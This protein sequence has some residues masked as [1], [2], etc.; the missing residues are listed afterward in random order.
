MTKGRQGA[1]TPKARTGEAPKAHHRIL[2]LEVTGGFLKDAKFEFADGL[3]CI[4]G[5]RGTGKTTVLEFV[6]Y[7]LALVPEEKAAPSR[8][9]SV[10]AIVQSNLGTGRI[11]LGVQTKHGMG[12]LAERPWNDSAQVLNEQGEAT[13]ISFERDSIFKADVYSQNEI[14]EIA[15][16]TSL[17]LSLLDKFIEDDVRRIEGEVRKLHRDLGQNAGELVRLDREMRDLRDSATEVPVLEE[18][19]KALQQ[20]AGPDAKIVNAAH[21]LKALRERERKT[22]EALR[23]DLRQVHTDVD[24]LFTGLK[25][26]V[27]SR[28]DADVAAGPNKDVFDAIAQHV[29][30]LTSLLDRGATKIGQQADAADGEVAKREATLAE[31]HAKQDAEYRDLVAKSQEETGRVTERTQLQRRYAEVTTARKELELRQKERHEREVRR[32]ELTSKLSDLRDERFRLRKNVAEHL[33]APLQP[34]IRVTITQA[35]NRDGYRALLTE[36]LKGQSMRY[37]A[38][39]DRIVQSASPDE[40]SVLVQRNDAAR[41]AERTGVD[42]DRS[43]KVIE[44]L[45][46]TEL[47]YR[48]E[49]IELEDLPRIELLD[50]RDY[51]DSAGLSTGQ[52]CTTI[53]PILLLESERPLLVDQPE[54]NLDNRYIYETVVKSLSGAKGRRQLIFVTHNPNIPV[55]GNAER[56]FVLTSDG[57]QGKLSKVGTVDEL[58]QEIE[59]LLEGGS[60]AFLLRKERYGH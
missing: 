59:L 24:S 36:A 8:A 10:K 17:Q 7:V 31:R 4:I 19:L 48:L 21:T 2:S 16:N 1:A 45:R 38:V 58:K 18:K 14:E 23:A 54:D 12:Y 47:L 29:K 13:A 6:R 30:E 41:L 11:R 33:L 28:V 52:R 51:K 53:L 39:V 56:V 43:K 49:T 57:K 42:E 3:N 37:T 40:L 44:A 22:L 26:R 34:T 15:T 32:Q 27:E 35:A 9:R 20:A 25:R 5:G 46:D 50:G 60:E 55:L